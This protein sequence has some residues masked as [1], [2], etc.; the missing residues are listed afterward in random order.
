MQI[1]V[2]IPNVRNI[3]VFHSSSPK[4]WLNANPSQGL[5]DQMADG[6]VWTAYSPDKLHVPESEKVKFIFSQQCPLNIILNASKLKTSLAGEGI[7]T[8]HFIHT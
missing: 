4:A 2:L 5:Q 6:T 3:T 7:M 8:C 1:L